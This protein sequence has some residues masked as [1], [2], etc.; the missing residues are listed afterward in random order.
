MGKTSAI[1][2]RL[3]EDDKQRIAENAYKIGM[4]VSQYIRFVATTAQVTA[5]ISTTKGE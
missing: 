2:I 3:S 5:Q 4:S 1:T